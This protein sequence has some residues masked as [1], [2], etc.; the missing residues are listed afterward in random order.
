MK[1]LSLVIPVLNEAGN[2]QALTEKIRSALQGFSF[3]VIWVDDGSKD[4]TVDEIKK[5]S[6]ANTWIRKQ[7]TKKAELSLTD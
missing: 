6:D 1:E 3:D 2:V 7:S 5:H 4:Q